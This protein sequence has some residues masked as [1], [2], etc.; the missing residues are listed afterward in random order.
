MNLTDRSANFLAEVFDH[1]SQVI[2]WT[3]P[4]FEG[5]P[6]R[7]VRMLQ[8]LTSPKP[9]TFTVFPND[10]MDEMVVVGPVS[11]VSLCAHHIIPFMGSAY[12]G[13]VPR[14]H[15]AGLSKIARTVKEFSKGLWVQ[16]ELTSTIA[17]HIEEHLNPVGLATVLE[18]EHLC[19]TIR[20][21]QSPGTLTTTSDMRGVFADHTRLART[22]FLSIINSRRA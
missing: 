1:P 10:G 14:D 22:E 13:Y 12:I 18:A 16:E 17:D 4:H 20:G 15:V 5:T 6:V 3:L 21:V 8:E 2:D 19:M 7:F 9:F 11:F